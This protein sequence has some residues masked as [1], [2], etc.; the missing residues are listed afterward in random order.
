MKRRD[1][2]K[3]SIAATSGVIFVNSFLGCVNPAIEGKNS[4]ELFLGFKNPPNDSR[5]FV[6]WWWN[7]NRLTKQ[8]ILREL[9]V[10][11]AAGIGGVEINPIAF[12]HG[13]DPMEYK[14]LTI[15][16][17]DWLEMLQTAL[18]GAKE[19]GLVCDMIV[20]SGWPFGGEFLKKEEQSQMVTIETLDVKGGAKEHFI[21]KDLLDK[22]DPNLHSKNKLVYKD[23]L[24]VRLLPKSANAFMEGKDLMG[25]ISNEELVVDVPKGDYV[26]YYVVKLTGYMAVIN[27]A[28]GAAGPVLNHYSKVA[29]EAYLNRISKFIV[30][31]VGDMGTHI[32]AMFCDSME[33]EGANWN[34]DLPDEFEKR[35][36]YSLLPYLPFVLKKVGHMGNPLNEEY[37]TKFSDEVVEEIKRVDLDFYKT[38]IE[39]FKERF[40][41][42]FNNWCHANNVK[43]RMQAYGRG[44]HPLEASMEIDIPECETWLFKDVGREYPDTGL[45]GRAPRM[46]NKYVSSGAVLAGKKIVSC[47]E[48][49]NTEMAFMATLENIKVAGDQSNISGVNHSILHGFNYSPLEAPFPGWIRYGAYFNEKNTWWPYF[50]KWTDYKARISYL[51]QNAVPQANVAILQP[52]TDLWLKKGPQR[53]P[54]PQEWYPEYQNNLWEAIHQNGGACDY[55]SENI[56]NTS[57][58]ENGSMLYNERTYSTIL[59]PEFETLDVKTAESLAKFADNGGR[60]VFIGKKPFKSPTYKNGD[61]ADSKVKQIV[62]DL[63]DKTNVVLYP[64]PKDNLIEWYGKLQV[65]LGLK[66]Y[67]RFIKTHKYLSQS[68]YLL[69]GNPFFFIT[70]TSLSE[71]ISVKAEFNV[72]NYL[73]PWLWNPETGKKMRYPTNGKNNGIDLEIPRATSVLIVFDENSNGKEFPAMD[74]NKKGKELVGAWNLQ[75]SHISGEKKDMQIETLVNLTEDDQTKEFAGEVIYEKT[76]SVDPTKYQY[77]DLGDVQ[78]ISELTLNGNLIGEKWYGAHIYDIGSALKTGENKLSIKLTTIIGNYVKSQK[79]NLVAQSWTNRQEYYPM[80][81]LGPVRIV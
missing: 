65:D 45:K 48:I 42:T 54:F 73:S 44:M 10:M 55:V 18:V 37:G 12:P 50:R 43:S 49:T 75:L 64:A 79:D 52:L 14:A 4:E 8:E 58:F 70:N 3:N 25:N 30:D 40:I 17:D 72:E 1:F 53:D 6:R 19:R 32:R 26:L 29:T 56:I 28:P 77:I 67:V 31:K 13:A 33:L 69:E 57:T 11:K 24:M 66:P 46:C 15:F 5:V 23:L 2:V 21:L 27:G 36:G 71:H 16:E 78:G 74:Y 20:G 9:D 22:V 51:L 76:F 34:D 47:E 59:L 39:L 41:D 60:I 80:G 68:N 61:S 38:R 63:F 35:R 7:G 81:I 62:E